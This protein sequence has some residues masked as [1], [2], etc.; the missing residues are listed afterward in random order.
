M[1]KNKKKEKEK[2]KEKKEKKEQQPQTMDFL[3]WGNRKPVL[4]ARKNWQ[5]FSINL[6]VP[7]LVL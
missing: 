1:W 2:E 3:I 6:S 4:C 7:E 5:G